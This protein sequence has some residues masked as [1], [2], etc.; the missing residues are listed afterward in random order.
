MNDL[1][2]YYIATEEIRFF[3][4]NFLKGECL[5]VFRKP[6]TIEGYF[7]FMRHPEKDK[8]MFTTFNV[9][10]IKTLNDYILNKRIIKYKNLEV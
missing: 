5:R 7:Q 9:Y 10:S 2:G 8:S 6:K 3:D 4:I 1:E